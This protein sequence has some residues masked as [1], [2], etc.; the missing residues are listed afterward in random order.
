MIRRPPIST[1]FPYT[2]LFRSVKSPVSKPPLTA[3][4]VGGG[5]DELGAIGAANVSTQAAQAALIP[6]AAG[7]VA[8]KL[9]APTVSPLSSKL[10][11]PLAFTEAW[12]TDVVPS[13]T[14]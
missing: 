4:F 1:L 8:V 5:G 12:P 7:S 14:L 3:R 2:T 9:C 6:F 13:N 10:Q 11:A